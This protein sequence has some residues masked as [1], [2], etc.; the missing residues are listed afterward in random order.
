M[1]T[2]E[3]K[4]AIYAYRMHFGDSL[5]FMFHTSDIGLDGWFHVC[6]HTIVSELPAQ[7]DARAAE[8][9]ALE[10]E[11][12]KVR[13]EMTKRITEINERIQSL[14]AIEHQP[15]EVLA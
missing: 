6:D 2:I 1:Q 11:R 9:A 3:I 7:F 13:A 15:S 8:V 14:L 10:H 12:D 5:I 4:G